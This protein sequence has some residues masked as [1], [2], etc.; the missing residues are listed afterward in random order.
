M[1]DGVEF[2]SFPHVVAVGRR[3]LLLLPDVEPG[4]KRKEWEVYVR[5]LSGS[6]FSISPPLSYN[7]SGKEM[8]RMA[9][10]MGEQTG[11][12]FVTTS[13]ACIP[14]DHVARVYVDTQENGFVTIMED[15]SAAQYHLESGSKLSCQKAVELIAGVILQYIQTRGDE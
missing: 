12:H 10:D 3:K 13:Q 9:H 8:A 4:K 6:S 11:C 7:K 2:Y 15:S 14:F 1:S 5:L